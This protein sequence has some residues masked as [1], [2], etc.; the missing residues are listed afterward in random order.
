MIN[1]IRKMLK[2]II[3]NERGFTLV[4]LMVVVTILA[5]LASIAIP[6]FSDQK[7]KAEE[8]KTKADITI[9]QNA[10]DM[11]YFDHGVY[12]DETSDLVSAGYLRENPVKNNGDTYDIGQ[13]GIVT[14]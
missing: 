10:V 2:R 6:R 5:I 12:P 8:M 14:E 7:Q 4:E 9:L 1:I 11:F 3:K 13:D